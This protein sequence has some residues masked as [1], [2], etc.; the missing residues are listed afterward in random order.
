MGVFYLQEGGNI[1]YVL[2]RIEVTDSSRQ[3]L[4]SL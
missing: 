2:S 4:H 3:V 1:N